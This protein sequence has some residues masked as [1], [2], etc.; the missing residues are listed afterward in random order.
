[1]Q[2]LRFQA[3][4]DPAPQG[5]K[6]YVGNGRFIEASTKLAPWRSAVADAVFRAFSDSGIPVFLNPVV[7]EATFYLPR[8]KSVKRRWP[9]TSPDLDKLCRGLG[10]ALETDSGVLAS[11]SLIVR[12]DARKLYAD[13]RPPGVEVFIREALE[14]DL[15]VTVSL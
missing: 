2:T 6:R 3:F 13:T 15:N 8:P 11:D 5:S 10:D 12:W 9:S 4:G 7:V 14:A 1:M